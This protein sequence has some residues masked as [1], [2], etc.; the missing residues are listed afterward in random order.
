[1]LWQSSIASEHVVGKPHFPE[2]SHCWGWGG[3]G[4]TRQKAAC[5]RVCVCESENEGWV[6][7]CLCV[8]PYVRGGTTELVSSGLGRSR[9]GN[10][11]SG[12]MR[13][14]VLF[15][16]PWAS[17]DP[18]L[19]CLQEGKRVGGWEG[20]LVTNRCLHGV[21]GCGVPWSCWGQVKVEEPQAWVLGT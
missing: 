2:E 13:I 4:G 15:G 14:W 10:H 1:M 11:P 7:R 19:G 20:N 8:Y 9:S 21:G 17:W 12:P 18:T 6:C 3:E 16:E 5:M